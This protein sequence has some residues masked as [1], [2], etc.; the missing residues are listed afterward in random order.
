M[1]H[2]TDPA[3]QRAADARVREIRARHQAHAI[4]T[5]VVV[6][7]RAV[8]VLCQGLED[9]PEPFRQPGSGDGLARQITTVDERRMTCTGRNA[10]EAR[11]ATL[12]AALG[13]AADRWRRFAAPADETPKRGGTLTYMIPAD[14]PPS[15]DAPPRD[16]LRDDPFG[17]AVLQR[18]DPGQPGQPVLDDRLRLRSV[19]RDAAADR[20]RQ[21]LHLQDPRRRQVPRR[22]AA[23]RRRCRGE[24]ERDHLPA[25][26][27]D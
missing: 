24:L 2:E 11:S 21:D 6:P 8:P 22:L 17:R 23:D 15:F 16:D 19:H 14:A 1:L 26:G 3:K 20:R 27:R 13:A 25:R 18:A 9:Q 7:D 12:A 10:M 4:M 5:A